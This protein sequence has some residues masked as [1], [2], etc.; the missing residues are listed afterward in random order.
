MN[1]SQALGGQE[2]HPGDN[3]KIAF[4]FASMDSSP[5]LAIY[6]DIG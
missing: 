2:T 6:S 1:P 5:G 4:E 3:V